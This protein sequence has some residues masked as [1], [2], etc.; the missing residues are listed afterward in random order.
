M[1]HQTMLGY[2][3]RD[4]NLAWPSNAVALWTQRTSEMGGLLLP[5]L[6]PIEL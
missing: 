2:Q 3:N 4:I 6:G 5:R 1:F